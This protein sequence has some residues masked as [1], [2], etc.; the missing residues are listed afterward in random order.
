ML[1]ATAIAAIFSLANNANAQLKPATDDGIAASPKVRQM[2]EE[3]ATA[4]LPTVSVAIPTV[5]YKTELE[6]VTAS[7]KAREML[8]ER[9]VVVSGTPSLE[10][11]TSSYRPTG[12]DGVTASPKLREQ[13][14]ERSAPI[15][16]APLK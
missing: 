5:S 12:A 11:T 10:V 16:I 1:F 14:D 8:G 13:L 6:G 3:R 7:P 2:L 15:I 4:A 9:R